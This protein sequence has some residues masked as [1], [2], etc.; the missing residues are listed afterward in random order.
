MLAFGSFSPNF[1]HFSLVG[2]SDKNPL[3]FWSRLVKF[4]TWW[5][6]VGKFPAFPLFAKK[7][8]KLRGRCRR[9]REDTN[10]F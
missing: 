3:D 7:M 8:W 10:T 4:P 5:G 1:K 6:K 9:S 2:K